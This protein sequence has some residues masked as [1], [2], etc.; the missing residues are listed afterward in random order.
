MS[1]GALS[2]LLETPAG[3]LTSERS[4]RG[5]RC[6]GMVTPTHLAAPGPP[7]PGRGCGG[8]TRFVC[9]HAGLG[10]AQQ[11][12]T[13]AGSQAGRVIPPP[14][15]ERSAVPLRHRRRGALM[16][17]VLLRLPVTRVRHM[18]G[19]GRNVPGATFP[20]QDAGVSV[21]PYRCASVPPCP[22]ETR[23]SGGRRCVPPGRP[24]VFPNFRE[25]PEA[26]LA[27]HRLW[28]G[29][30]A[31]LRAGFK[32]SSGEASRRIGGD[33]GKHPEPGAP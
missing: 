32:I 2:C 10:P 24:G 1:G 22:L 31:P 23:D 28:D 7:Y 8:R 14:R 11:R 15:R 18:D 17:V 5:P 26:C 3:I 16:S 33:G 19:L 30:G 29:C 21:P 6:A 20:G 9:G 13:L 27:E 25:A 12:R 4:A